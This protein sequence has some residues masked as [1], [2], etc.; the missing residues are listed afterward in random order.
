MPGTQLQQKNSAL[1]TWINRNIAPLITLAAFISTL[2][3]GYFWLDSRYAKAAELEQLEQRFEIKMTS[4][5]IRETNARIWQLEDRLQQRPDDLT[6]K[7][8]LRK[9]QENKNRLEHTLDE[10][11]KLP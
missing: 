6:A 4:D 3:A 8:E 11:Q 10:L 7:K 1:G 2:F 9:L 5:A